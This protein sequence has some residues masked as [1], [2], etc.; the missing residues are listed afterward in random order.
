MYAHIAKAIALSW[1]QRWLVRMVMSQVLK[2]LNKV[3]KGYFTRSL[4]FEIRSKIIAEILRLIDQAKIK[5]PDL[6]ID[7]QALQCAAWVMESDTIQA[8]VN[9]RTDKKIDVHARWTSGYPKP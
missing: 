9:Q 3:G 8:K 7:E 2:R 6:E 1:W 4:A 5:T